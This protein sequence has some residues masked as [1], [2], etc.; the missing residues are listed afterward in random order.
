MTQCSHH[1]HWINWKITQHNY[2]FFKQGLAEKPAHFSST[3]EHITAQQNAVEGLHAGPLV[4][5]LPTIMSN[6]GNKWWCDSARRVS[7]S[8]CPHRTFMYGFIMHY[9][10]SRAETYSR[11]RD[12]TV[13]DEVLSF[14]VL[15][16]DSICHRF[17]VQ[18]LMWVS[19]DTTFLNALHW[20]W[21][22]PEIVNNALN[23]LVQHLGETQFAKQN[24]YVCTPTE[25]ELQWH[26]WV[27]N[28]KTIT[29]S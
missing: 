7:P 13:S 9:T 16:N 6:C 10:N 24:V 22:W 11:H 20:T 18:Q 15:W 21:I 26:T 28:T 25:I 1:Q 29:L 5:L 17:K 3:R 23:Q 14:S 12:T 19:K 2:G 8:R 27:A 4:T